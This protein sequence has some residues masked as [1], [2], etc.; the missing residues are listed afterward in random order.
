M[1]TII[2]GGDARFEYLARLLS[3]RGESVGLYGR[4]ACPWANAVGMEALAHA[5]NI[6]LKG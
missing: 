5:D 4:E 1:K 2:I 6:V 3:E